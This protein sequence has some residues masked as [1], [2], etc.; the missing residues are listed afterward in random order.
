MEVLAADLR[1]AF[2]GGVIEHVD[3]GAAAH[4]DQPFNF[5]HD[6]RF[7]NHG[8]GDVQHLGDLSLRR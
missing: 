3:P 7:T 5:Q 6:Q 8:T 4:F 1:R 2:S